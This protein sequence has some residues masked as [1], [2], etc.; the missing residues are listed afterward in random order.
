MAPKAL[1]PATTFPFAERPYTYYRANDDR[2][3]RATATYVRREVVRDRS[4]S[5]QPQ[6]LATSSSGQRYG[7]VEGTD[8]VYAGD[9]DGTGA[10]HGWGTLKFIWGDEYTG[11]FSRGVIHGYGEMKYADGRKHAGLW[12]K[13]DRAGCGVYSGLGGERI[14]DGNWFDGKPAKYE[15]GAVDL[16]LIVSTTMVQRSFRRRSAARVDDL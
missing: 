11:Q 1:V 13:G 8:G 7:R 12:E 14:R 3:D 6:E 5:I 4:G 15:I 10:R 16:D 9:V 2:R